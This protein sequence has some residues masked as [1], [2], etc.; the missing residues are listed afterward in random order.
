MAQ[1]RIFTDEDR[2]WLKENYPHLSNKKCRMHFKCGYESLKNWF[3]IVVLIIR[4]LI[5][6]ARNLTRRPKVNGKMRKSVGIALIALIMSK[7][8]SALLM[9]NW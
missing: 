9:E 4:M 1:E 8:E 3:M 7:V 2:E 5:S 6:I